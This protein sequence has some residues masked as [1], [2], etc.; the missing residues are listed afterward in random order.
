MYG[1]Y[2]M[3]TVVHVTHE[4]V[5]KVGG[6][7]AVLHGLITAKAYEQAIGRT[8]LA[9]PVFEGDG[10]D[11]LGPEGE[12]LYS[13]L[14]GIYGSEHADAFRE[15]EGQFGVGMV[16]GRRAFE[17]R[18]SGVRAH[19]EVL[20]VEVSRTNRDPLNRFKRRLYERF[21]L[22]SDRYESAWDYEQYVRIAEPA[23]AAL[24]ALLDPG[25]MPC[26]VI[27]HEFMG[28]PTALKAAMEGDSG[29]RTIFYAHEAAPMRRLVEDHPGHDTMFYNVMTRARAEAQYVEDVFGP[30]G[31]FFKHALVTRSRFCDRLFAVGDYTKKELRFLGSAFEDAPVDLVYNGIP[32][33]EIS[34]EENQKAKSLLQEYTENLLGYRPSYV[35]SHVTRLV[36]SKG[37]WRDFK[38]LA[39]LDESFA[40]QGKTGVLFILSTQGGPR[41]SEEV[42][43]MEEEYGWPAH[44]RDGYPDLIHGERFFHLGV[45]DYNRTAKAIRIVFVNQFGWSRAACGGRM[46]EEMTFM[47]LR[48]GTDVEFGQSVYE[49]FGIAQV[50]PLSFG[51]LCVVSNVCGCVGFVDRVTD[52]ERGNVI[53][54]DYTKLD[55]PD[56]SIEELRS[57]GIPQRDEVEALNS[58]EVAQEILRRLPQSDEDA[59]RMLAEGYRTASKMSWEVV[60]Q[61]YFLPGL[62]RADK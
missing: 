24:Q 48:K 15:I 53:V 54:A 27:A 47:D 52:G 31:D 55:R 22:Q 45:E 59:E 35:F 43:K 1:G 38:V 25:D 34:P 44:H 13:S 37:L 11:R 32:T 57:I 33:F 20:L 41:S 19:P 7:G 14:D 56:R 2:S 49:P 12:V 58:R 30:Q 17:D 26:F 18:A 51:A 9:G 28:M 21:G 61:D 39:H 5:Q 40:A 50:E 10:P 42:L 46:P 16:Y 6:I 8:V 4:A 36:I 62:S 3:S 23:Y 29:F 60:V